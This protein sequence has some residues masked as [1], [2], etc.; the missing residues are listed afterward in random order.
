MTKEN[1]VFRTSEI[2]SHIIN[3]M[4]EPLKMLLFYIKD[5]NEP[6]FK[7]VFE[8]NK[9]DINST[10]TNQNTLLCLATQCN[11]LEIVNYLLKYGANPNKQNV[12]S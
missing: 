10:D 3:Y 1:T 2:K 5:N 4:D 12:N 7:E 11:A 6:K 8:K 9:I